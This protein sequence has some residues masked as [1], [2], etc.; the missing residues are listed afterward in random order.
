MLLYVH[1]E[2][3]RGLLSYSSSPMTTTTFA[4]NCPIC[5]DKLNDPV[6][7]PCGKPAGLYSQLILNHPNEPREPG[8]L[9]CDACIK[10]HTRRFNNP[11]DVTCPTCREPF[12][13]GIVTYFIHT[14]HPIPPGTT[15]PSPAEF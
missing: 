5:L 10:A 3:D 12:T 1:L 9:G 4:L 15:M 11:Q 6:V 2:G 8:H 13:I 7:T 14:T